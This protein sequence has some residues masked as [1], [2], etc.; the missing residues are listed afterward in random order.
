MGA[1]GHIFRPSDINNTMQ[2][3]D[4]LISRIRYVL[5]CQ[6]GLVDFSDNQTGFLKSM[7]VSS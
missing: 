1:L 3:S 6:F 7:N 2:S 5:R 4:L